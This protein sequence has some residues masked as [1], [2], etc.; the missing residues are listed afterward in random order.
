[1]TLQT[2]GVHYG[3]GRHTDEVSGK[4]MQMTTKMSYAGGFCCIVSLALSKTSFCLTLLRISDGWTRGAVWFILVSINAVLIAHGTIQ[5]VQCWPTPRLWDYDVPGS[6]MKAG[7]VE[8][9]NTFSTSEFVIGSFSRPGSWVF[10]RRYG[11]VDADSMAT[12]YSGSMDIIL[13]ILPWKIILS[14]QINKRERIGVVI[15]MSTSIL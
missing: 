7:V 8:T 10:C 12:V 2:V 3:L 11:R 9:Y 13:A 4:A 15:A 14:V 6:C 5:W 1:M